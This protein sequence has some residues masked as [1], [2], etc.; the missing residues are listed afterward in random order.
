MPFPDVQALAEYWQ[1]CPPVHLLLK[2]FVGYKGRSKAEMKA[3]EQAFLNQTPT[4]P[5]HQL[6]KS[7]RDWV[8]GVKHHA[9]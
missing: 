1:E 2:A 8:S 7:V 4:V 6:P 5:F 3:A 9:C